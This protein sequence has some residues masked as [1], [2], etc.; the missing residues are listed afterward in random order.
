MTDNPISV[1]VKTAAQRLGASE[2]FI[3]GEI[4]KGSL[5]AKRFGAKVLISVKSIEEYYG[6]GIDWTP[7]Q[8]PK[9]ANDARRKTA[10]AK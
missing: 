1:S 3:R 2:S 6:G 7:G 9:A 10:V 4:R 8:A 5:K